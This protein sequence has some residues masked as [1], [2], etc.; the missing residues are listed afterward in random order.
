MAI[1]S[2]NKMNLDNRIK[3]IEEAL[4]VIPKDERYKNMSALVSY[5]VAE[6]NPSNPTPV[7]TILFIKL[8]SIYA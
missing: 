3:S 8:N 4:G 5:E 6:M 2:N 1:A 7:S